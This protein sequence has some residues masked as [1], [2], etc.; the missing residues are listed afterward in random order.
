MPFVKFVP[1]PEQ[2]A[3]NAVIE[4]LAEAGLQPCLNCLADIDDDPEGIEAYCVACDPNV[5]VQVEEDDAT[6]GT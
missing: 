5:Y 6:G 1:T 4:A 2:N 3:E